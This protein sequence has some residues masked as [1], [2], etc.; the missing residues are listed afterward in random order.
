MKIY[1]PWIFLFLLFASCSRNT[2]IKNDSNSECFSF[3]FMTDIHLQPEKNATIGFLQAIDSVNSLNPDFVLTGGDNIMDALDQSYDRSDS[4]YTLYD[5]CIKNL[6]MPVY[7]C[8]GNHELFGIYDSTGMHTS[9]PEYAKNM[10]ENRLHKRYYSFDHKNWHFI[11]LDGIE[12]NNDNRYYGYIDSSQTEWLK[13][14]LIKVGK[15]R[16]VVVV[17]HIPLL[18][19]GSQIMKGPIQGMTESSIITN[20][21]EIRKVL[22]AY[23]VKLVLQGHL[24][25]L[26]D[27]QY[28]GIH[29]ITGG[30]V[31]AQWWEG[32]RFGME[33]GFMQI[34]ITGNNFS[35]KYIDFGWDVESND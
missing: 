32:P 4:L 20:S 15:N 21:N 8:I 23:N 2:A 10:Y 9:H 1:F 17:T 11:I 34:N 35:W 26:E 14:D 7:S 6:E 5:S 30:A 22:E 18:S 27:I 19:I 29:Y 13:T 3:V 12:L 24:H 31:C 16:P 28:N 25:F 33:E